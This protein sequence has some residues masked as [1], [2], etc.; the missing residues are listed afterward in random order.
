MLKCS[1]KDYLHSLGALALAARLKRLSDRMVH[2]ARALYEELG[3]PIEPNWY[4]VF[5]LL[6][7]RGPLA[8]TEIAS[9]LGWAHPSVVAVVAKMQKRGLIVGRASREDGRRT[10]LTLSK[11]GHTQLATAR[12]VWKAAAGGV[13]SLI[14]EAGGEVMP[15]VDA[16]ERAFTRRG[17]RQRTL[18][19][20]EKLR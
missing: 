6:E 7:L 20:L 18:E 9:A 2:D 16:L 11:K 15:L 1:S 8:V 13:Q 12:P 17:L 5:L 4:L 10:L 14:D 19:K 3:L